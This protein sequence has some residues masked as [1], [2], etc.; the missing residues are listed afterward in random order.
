MYYFFT[1]VII[2]GNSL[3]SM[4]VFLVT[5]ER[6][7]FDILLTLTLGAWKF[8]WGIVKYLWNALTVDVLLQ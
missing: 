6:A 4:L 2:K 1:L 8:P 3:K 7:L 5:D